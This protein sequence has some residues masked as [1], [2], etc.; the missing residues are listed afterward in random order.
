MS[1]KKLL[2]N[3]NSPS[4]IKNFTMEELNLLSEE[5]RQTIVETVSKNGGHLASNLGV[6]ELTVALHTM[7]DAPADKII[8]DVGHQS[9]AHKILTGRYKQIDT[10][11]TEGGLSGF[12]KRSES[13]YDT[14]DTGHSS[15]SISA[16]FGIACASDIT[17]DDHYTIAV[18]GD[19]A[20]SG[21]L[22]YEGLN[23]AGRSKTNFIVILNDN[24]MSI[25]K[26]VGSMAR[27]LS[28]LRI[29]P[30]YLDTK[31]HVQGRLQR[32]PGIGSRLASGVRSFKDWVS[33]TFFGYRKTIFEQLGFTY[34][35]IFD[36]H[37]I[38]QLQTAI[39]AAKRR[40]GPVLI[41]IATT[42]GKGY[43]YAEKN[44]KS[45]HG[46]SA[47][48]I[49]TG[50]AKTSSKCYSDVVG[51][52]LC[53]SADVD[54]RICAITAAMA[55]G[56]GLSEFS[57]KYKD[58]FYDVG[59]AEEHAVT[60]ACGLAAG[61]AIP[62]FCVYSTFLQ[63]SYDQIL[64][65]AALQNLH[66]ILA[67]DRAGIVGEDGETHQGIF[68]TAFLN[69]IPNVTVYSPS[70]FSELNSVMFNALYNIGGVVAVRYPRGG[71]LYMPE[72]FRPVADPY[73]FYGDTDADAL[74]ITYG[75]LFSF[76]CLARER[77]NREGVRV[78]ILKLNRIKPIPK[79]A[80]RKAAG[81]KKCFFFEE[82][83]KYG[84]VG[85]AFGYRMYR[86]GYK[87]E[88]YLSAIG[89]YVKQATVKSALKQLGLDD[90]GMYKTI[91]KNL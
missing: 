87:G 74:I 28:M 1:E 24:K 90:D 13:I 69:T 30:S 17:N 51:E 15:T 91:K 34:Y 40:H 68:D 53:R 76:A 75:R 22:A 52:F 85:E 88:Y 57:K 66:I 20:L 41:H 63:R 19:G 89:D 65:D 46:I 61:N 39:K 8:W 7:F 35:G 80:V 6:V 49:E 45:F 9:Y 79:N 36:G 38:G 44:P 81:Y 32:I 18:I 54:K 67:I 25:S 56:T 14:F 31:M 43:E 62:V 23:N 86:G 5:L 4:D 78:C 72:D 27:Y 77:L 33:E 2:E 16:G 60:F 10:I 26:N 21:G 37:D 3:I 73:V 64:H 82:G 59:I 83:I 70:Y 55:I 84:G 47:F 50:E 12:P 71:E 11:R 29:K 58:R 48:D 42:K